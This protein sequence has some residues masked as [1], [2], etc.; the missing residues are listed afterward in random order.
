MVAWELSFSDIDIYIRSQF[1]RS[2]GFS[3]FTRFSMPSMPLHFFFK[4][5][6]STYNITM[7]TPVPNRVFSAGK[8]VACVQCKGKVG[9]AYRQACSK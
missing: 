1:G 3:L 8:V 6:C 9:V 5:R 4:H 2:G 7:S